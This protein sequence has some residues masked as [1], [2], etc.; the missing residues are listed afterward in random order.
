MSWKPCWRGYCKLNDRLL[1]Y[2]SDDNSGP[3]P[4]SP[5]QLIY[6]HNIKEFPDAVE[7]DEIVDPSFMTRQKISRRHSRI[8][9]LLQQ[10]WSR[11]KSEYLTA[12]RERSLPRSAG[13][14]IDVGHVVLIDNEDHSPRSAW[15]MGVI[16]ELI[17]GEDD[18]VR[19]VRIKTANGIFLRPVSKLYPLEVYSNERVQYLPS[20]SAQDQNDLSSN[21]RPKRQAAIKALERISRS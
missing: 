12:L 8:T 5:S 2:V 19:T 21:V 13:S 14:V 20:S 16:V 17:K 6:G 7:L 9:L 15:K 18:L 11:W 1:T 10:F 4:L 3:Q